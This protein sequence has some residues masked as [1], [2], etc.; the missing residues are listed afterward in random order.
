MI[1]SKEDLK[2]YEL[3]DLKANLK[4][5]HISCLKY[6]IGLILGIENYRVVHFLRILRKLEYLINCH[7]NNFL[8]NIISLILKMNLKRLRY[9]YHIHI[10]PNTVGY[11]L[12]IPHIAGGVLLNCECMGNNCI[13]NSGVIVGKN[14]KGKPIIGNNVHLTPGVK[15]IGKVR[16]GNNV[17]VAPNSVVVKDID[18]NTVVSGVP[19]KFLKWC[20][21]TP[22]EIA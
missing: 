10:R 9:K 6:K 2:K 16:I 5:E 15:V 12:Y 14:D 13:A 21:E 19:A 8:A 1:L 22:N 11:G 7:P 4:T 17:I 18:D 20:N 3:E